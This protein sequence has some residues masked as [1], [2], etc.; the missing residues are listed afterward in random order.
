MGGEVRIC[1]RCGGHFD[2]P[3]RQGPALGMVRTA[4]SRAAGHRTV[5]VRVNDVIVHQ[6]Q[7]RV[8]AVTGLRAWRPARTV[9]ADP[10]H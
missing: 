7:Q 8:D 6:C 2:L 9:G 3:P 1:P 10:P 4:G 5:S